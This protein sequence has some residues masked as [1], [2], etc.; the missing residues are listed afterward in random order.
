MTDR[1]WSRM[2]PL[3][4]AIPLVLVILAANSLWAN[5]EAGPPPESDDSEGVAFFEKKILP[6]LTRY[7]YECHSHMSDEPKGGLRVD[8]R[9]AIRAGGGTGPGIVPGDPDASLVIEAVRY[10]EDAYQMPPAGKL[11]D[12]ILRDLERW[13]RI[14]APD[15]RDEPSVP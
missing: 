14:G 5:G 1:V 8:S 12:E 10:E 13:V 2:R 15:P 3:M 4:L 11:S 9:S 6:V 7:C